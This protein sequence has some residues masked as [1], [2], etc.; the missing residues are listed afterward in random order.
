MKESSWKTLEHIFQCILEQTALT[1]DSAYS[2]DDFI[3][4]SKSSDL[5]GLR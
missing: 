1:K 4:M 3:Y 5:Q 2:F